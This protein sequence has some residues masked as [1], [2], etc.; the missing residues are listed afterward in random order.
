MWKVFFVVFL[1]FLFINEFIKGLSSV[2]EKVN[3]F[4]VIM[5]VLKGLNWFIIGVICSNLIIVR[6][7]KYIVNIMII[8]SSIFMMFCCIFMVL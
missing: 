3:V 5:R 1:N 6:G 2:C 7:V 4:I 8:I